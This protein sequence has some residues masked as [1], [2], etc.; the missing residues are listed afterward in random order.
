V[1]A[2]FSFLEGE[3][4]MGG[5]HQ[6]E[7]E[8]MSSDDD[9]FA[10]REAGSKESTAYHEAG[11]AVV[12]QEL[13]L[14]VRSVSIVPDEET[15]GCCTHPKTHKFT[16]KVNEAGG[17]EHL[18]GWTRRRAEGSIMILWAG[19]LAQQIYL[20]A[21]QEEVNEGFGVMEINGET[22]ITSHSDADQIIDL[23]SALMPDPNEHGAYQEWLRIRTRNML[24]HDLVWAAVEAVARELLAKDKLSGKE[25]SAIW[26]AS[27]SRA[28]EQHKAKIPLPT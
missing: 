11:H 3:K 28:F 23:T 1:A 24:R 21:H 7:S 22:H 18:D 6:R 26:R 19:T 2:G 16:R 8:V 12:A 10:D 5:M 9:A 17:Y 13:G 25:V 4:T 15:A 27:Y 20:D 14:G